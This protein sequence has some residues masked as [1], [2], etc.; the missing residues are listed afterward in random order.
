MRS[1]ILFS[2]LCCLALVLYP[3]PPQ[4]SGPASAPA[5]SPASER[6]LLDKYCVTCHS[7]KLK[8]GGLTLE[9]LDTEHVAD[10]AETWEK[11]VRKIHGGTMP[12][13]GMPRPDQ[14]SLDSLASTLEVSLDRAA[15]SRPEPGRAGI[16]RLNRAEYGNAIRDLLGVQVDVSSLLPADDESN[17][18]D[19]LAD[20]LKVSPSLLEQYLTASRTVSSL[21][22]GDRG[23][24]PVG[25]VY[26]LPPTLAQGGHIEGLPLGTRG[27]ILIRHNFPLDGE[28]EFSVFLLRN[29]V[30]YMPGLE[31]PHQF[32]ITVDGVRVFLSH[33]GGEEDNKMMD[34]NLGLA[35]NTI[36]ARLRVRVPVKAGAREVGVTFIARNHAESVE[37]L[38]PFTRNLDLQDMNGIPLIN[39]VQV[40]G[41]FAATGSGDTPSRRRIFVCHPASEG[42]ELPCARK[43]LSTLAR[44]AYRR[45][46]N[47]ADL[48][49]LLSFYQK[50]RNKG[51]FDAGIETALRLILTDPKFLYRSESDPANAGPGTINR[52]SDLELASRLSFFLW[53]SLP[54]DELLN[55]AT[56][57]KLH[58]PA[59]L[60]TQVRRML[61]DSKADALV[62]NFASEWLFLRNLQSVNPASEDFP[63]FDENLR[64]AFLE[65]TEMFVGSVMKE[66]RN[67]LDLLTANYTFV[68]ERLAKHYGIPNVYGSQFRRVTLKD[69]ARRGLLG[70]GSILTVTSYPTRTS[71]VLRGK[72]ILENI[73]GTP[74]PAPPP[75]VPA[76]K[77]NDEGGQVTTVRER[78][79][80]HRKNPACATCH[81][82]MDPLGF[83]LDNFDAVGQW[84]TK[85]A[86]LPIDA[87][88][89]LADGTK[90]SGVVD[91]RKALLAHPERFVSTM[92]EKLMTY[93]LGRGLEYYDMPVVRGIT[94]DAARNDYRFSSIVMGIVK[95]TPFQMRRAR[96]VEAAPLT[97]A[98]RN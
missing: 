27:G 63:N 77:E 45:P 40:T 13:L 44:R 64:R 16:H 4:S 87:S 93:A 6:A 23:V 98:A 56:Q 37:P 68:N 70:Q 50:G 29:I 21:A 18:F 97:A 15:V 58:E 43:I 14:A 12:P 60:Q 78:L 47:D 73:T 79:E 71:P 69:D 96:D 34:T 59:V 8:T 35:G 84:R 42:E 88:G 54:D 66:D 67:V 74:T 52:I 2:G 17:G 25:Q 91:L 95:S 20:V 36:D 94:H 86:G 92:T 49:I 28:Y 65:E 3:A 55:V 31:Y 83:S 72:W 1:L 46:V 89:Q 22:I 75:N 82:V 51:S 41:P 26:Q 62:T 48:E 19:N 39:R 85:E 24:G 7:Q 80:E 90:I 10:G 61:A 9:K 11:V 32:E 33:V 57:G 81:R 38:Q 53:S 76:L 5:M 30:G